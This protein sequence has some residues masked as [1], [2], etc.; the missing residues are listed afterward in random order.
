MVA[1]AT[2]RRQHTQEEPR[3]P[4]VPLHALGGEAELGAGGQADNVHKQPTMCVSS[5]QK[6]EPLPTSTPLVT[7]LPSPGQRPE[8]H[9]CDQVRHQGAWR[10]LQP[11]PN[12]L[13]L[14]SGSSPTQ[15]ILMRIKT[16]KNPLKEEKEPEKT[17]I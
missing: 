14:F 11:N 1:D 2:G 4:C 5:R 3:N 10:R 9:S 17:M 13:N 6:P 16:S 15:V 12:P 8:A 7:A